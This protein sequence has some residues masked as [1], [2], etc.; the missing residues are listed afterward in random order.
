MDIDGDGR[1]A[2]NGRPFAQTPA[3]DVS[4]SEGMRELVRQGMLKSGS[5][6]AVIATL[7]SMAV[8]DSEACQAAARRLVLVYRAYVGDARRPHISETVFF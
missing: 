1:R 4:A 7:K 3:Q 6:Q 8:D 2:S 5:R